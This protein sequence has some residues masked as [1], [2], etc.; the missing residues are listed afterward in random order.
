MGYFHPVTGMINDSDDNSV[1][2][3]DLELNYAHRLFDKEASLVAGVTY[4]TDITKGGKKYE[5]SDVITTPVTPRFGPPIPYN[6]IVRTLSNERGAL[7]RI[8]DSTTTLAGFY[9]METFSPT[10]DITID[11]S[12]R[13][14]KL[15]FDMSGNEITDYDYA[16]RSYIDGIGQYDL[17]K[18]YNLFSAKLGLV[19]K[20]TE[21]TN[22]YTSIATANQA[23]TTGELS[24]NMSLEKSTNVNYEIGLKAR[25]AN[26]TY[27]LALYQNDVDDEIIQILDASGNSIYDNAGKTQK[28]GLE[29]NTVYKLSKAMDLGG[30]YAY[31]DFKFVTF[32][33]S[34]RGR[35]VSRDGNALPY[36]P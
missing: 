11:M 20:L 16:S 12:T 26:F 2:G 18:T 28:R 32:N 35:L 27:D 10:E 31:S 4:K 5:Y 13:N 3:T 24:E 29:F 30:S 7:A 36:I 8:E 1:Y 25:S 15:S 6:E 23:P 33:E 19:Y 34:V 21:S 14:D 9:L 17:D 22:M